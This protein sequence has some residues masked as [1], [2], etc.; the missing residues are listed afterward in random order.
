M[1]RLVRLSEMEDAV[2]VSLDARTYRERQRLNRIEKLGEAVRDG[3]LDRVPCS[4]CGGAE[5][6]SVGSLVV[7]DVAEIKRCEGCGTV[8][9]REGRALGERPS[10]VIV[11]RPERDH[12]NP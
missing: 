4:A 7:W 6:G 11:Y 8:L 12:V 3:G 2:G 9:H 5:P 10:V 1:D